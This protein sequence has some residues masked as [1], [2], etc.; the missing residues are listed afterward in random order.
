[1]ITRWL[2]IV[3][4]IATALLIILFLREKTHV[5]TTAAPTGLIRTQ[6]I[7]IVDQ[8]GKAAA[9][10][11]YDEKTSAP[12]L[13]FR[14]GSGRDVVS[15]R[16]GQNGNASMYFLGKPGG[17]TVSLGYLSGSDEK[18]LPGEDD[19]LGN[20]GLRIR[21]AD[22]MKSFDSSSIDSTAQDRINQAIKPVKI[23]PR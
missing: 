23:A 17:P 7:E 6:H 2:T 16:I 15:V 9:L 21:V 1:M 13:T 11:G 3:N 14:D 18:P 12:F 20:W 8:Q 22:R 10:L 19:P 5:P 4:C